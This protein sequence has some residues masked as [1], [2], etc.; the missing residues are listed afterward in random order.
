MATETLETRR[1]ELAQALTAAT[2][3]Y[4]SL[5]QADANGLMPDAVKFSPAGRAAKAAVNAAFEAVRAHN[6]LIVKARKAKVNP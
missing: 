6:V 2:A 4:Y 5:G 1:D 3:A